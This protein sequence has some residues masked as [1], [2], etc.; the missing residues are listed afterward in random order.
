[1]ENMNT[2]TLIKLQ[3]EQIEK[4]KRELNERLRIATKRVDHIERAYRKE[5]RPL[6]AKDYEQQQI[7]DRLTFDSLQKSRIESSK[8]AHLQDLETKKRMAR[9]MDDYKSRR[10]E[11]TA[12]KGEEFKRRTEVAHKKIADEK[13]K[14]RNA[15]IQEREEERQRIEEEE[16][17]RREETE[18]AARLEAGISF[19]SRSLSSTNI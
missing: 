9:M 2:D 19:L 14:R 17:K 7:N 8:I 10:A 5:E 15:I 11:I 3:V 18:E 16:R 13:A 6:L 12:K 4:E 1:M